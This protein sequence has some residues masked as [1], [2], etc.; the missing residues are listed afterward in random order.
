MKR[1]SLLGAVAFA[2]LTAC[3]RNEDNVTEI[4]QDNHNTHGHWDYENPNWANQGYSECA[5]LVQSP[6]DIVT[7]YTL[8]TEL[9]EITM[10]YGEFPVK[11]VDNGHTV[12]V[13][14]S[15]GS[16]EYNNDTYTLK[17]FHYHG[18]SEHYI[19]GKPSPMEVHFVHQSEK[20]GALIVLGVMVEGGGADNQAFGQYL[21]AFPK[22]KNK[23]VALTETIDPVKM[24]PSSKKYYNYTGSLTTP[25]CSQ[26]INWIVFKEVVK[27]SD[28]QLSGFTKAYGHNARPIQKTGS[29]TVF[30]S[31]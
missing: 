27:I 2:M 1:K 31:K 7:K 8:K 15:K 3:S 12:Q 10:N 30:E 20:T 9:P 6:I 29:R 11:I 19:D 14:A 26:G 24:F 5:G 16:I 28:A 18:H 4:P 13:N 21:Q 23:E 22:D 25:P 17:Q